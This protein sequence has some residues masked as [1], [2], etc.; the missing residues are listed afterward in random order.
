M[1]K[2]TDTAK[3]RT[4]VSGMT[5]GVANEVQQM[6]SGYGTGVSSETHTYNSMFQLTR[7]QVGSALDISYAY[8][9]T[10]NNGKITSQTDNNSSEQ[11]LYAY[12]ALN[13]LISAQT[14]GTG[15]WGQSYTYDGYGNLTD[16]GVIK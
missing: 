10:Q 7:L 8:S 3:P 2:M 16:Q 5:Y 6:T 9:A 12:D 11:V 4:L 13:R 15:G 14:A 1:S